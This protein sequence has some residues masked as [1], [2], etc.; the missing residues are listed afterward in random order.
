MNFDEGQSMIGKNIDFVFLGSCTNGRIEDFREF[1]KIVKGKKKASN[2]TAWLVPGSH[3]VEKAINPTMLKG[4]W[5]IFLLMLILISGQGLHAQREIKSLLHDAK[6]LK[7]S[8]DFPQ[9]IKTYK[10]VLELDVDN[11][12]AQ[13]GL[14][15]IYL[16]ICRA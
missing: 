6:K 11:A 13:E 1:T 3:Q 2:V 9:A 10:Q 12:S 16:Y 14:I 7:G 8:L 15:D 4:T 5:S